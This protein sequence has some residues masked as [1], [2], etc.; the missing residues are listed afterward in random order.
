[1]VDSFK[2]E[3]KASRTQP[4][5]G[6]RPLVFLRVDEGRTLRCG[7]VRATSV[8]RPA[9]LARKAALTGAARRVA[10]AIASRFAIAKN[11]APAV[12]ARN[13]HHLAGMALLAQG[14]GETVAPISMV[15]PSWRNSSSVCGTL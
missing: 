13:A 1:M 3:V 8:G 14:M 12:I 2:V 9:D 11:T 5:G 6:D 10:S 15:C 7:V 4:E